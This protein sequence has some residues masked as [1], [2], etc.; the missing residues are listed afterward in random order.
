[1]AKDLTVPIT[2]IDKDRYQVK[3]IHLDNDEKSVMAV[4]SIGYDELIEWDDFVQDPSGY[5]IY[6]E[7]SGGG[8]ATGTYETCGASALSGW[9]EVMSAASA[10]YYRPQDFYNTKITNQYIMTNNVIVSEG[11][12]L[13]VANPYNAIAGRI[14][15]GNW[16]PESNIRDF[17]EWVLK[18]YAG[19]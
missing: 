18:N 14:N 15:A 3:S 8:G 6:S 7:L 9:F 5:Q 4:F 13:P 10:N 17:F 11:S 12:G 16:T 1:M 19:V 2:G